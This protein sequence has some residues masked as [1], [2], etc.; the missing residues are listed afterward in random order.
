MPKNPKLYGLILGLVFGAGWTGIMALLNKVL[1]RSE[2]PVFYLLMAVFGSL[3]FGCF[4][5]LGAKKRQ[6]GGQ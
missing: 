4:A 1:N 2:D 5:Y 6:D 3:I